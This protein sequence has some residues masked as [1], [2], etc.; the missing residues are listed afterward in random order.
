MEINKKYLIEEYT[1]KHKSMEE[2]SIELG[3]S[4]QKIMR[5]IHK[6]NI[7]IR[8]VLNVG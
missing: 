5:L 3:T 7:P 4:P 2:I 8:S 1:I 6:F